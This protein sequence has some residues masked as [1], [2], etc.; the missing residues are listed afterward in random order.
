M[1][2]R[3]G[4]FFIVDFKRIAQIGV[5]KKVSVHNCW[6]YGAFCVRKGG[7]EAETN[8]KFFSSPPPQHLHISL[9]TL[10]KELSWHK[11]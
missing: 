6:D 4:N 1:R 3:G 7:G 8:Q 5:K 9:F 2:N 11:S 10:P